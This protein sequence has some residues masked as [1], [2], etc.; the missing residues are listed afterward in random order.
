MITVELT[1]TQIEHLAQGAELY[2]RCST[3]IESK[4]GDP[5]FLVLVKNHRRG[6]PPKG[7]AAAASPKPPEE[8]LP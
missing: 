7:A 6:R 4:E 8:A 1:E 3:L 2:G 5:V